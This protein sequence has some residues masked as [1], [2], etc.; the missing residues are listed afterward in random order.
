MWKKVIDELLRIRNL[1]DDWDREGT[2]APYPSLVDRAITLAMDF[3][4]LNNPPAERVL[5]S[6]NGTI[7]FEWHTPAGY[8][9]IEVTSPRNAESRFVP[10]GSKST[11]VEDFE[12]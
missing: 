8:Q 5:V 9:E 4:A 1:E 10:I 12:F 7:Y 3:E 2:E 11:I 6:V